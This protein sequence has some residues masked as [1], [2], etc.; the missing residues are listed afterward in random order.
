MCIHV[1]QVVEEEEEEEHTVWHDKYQ[2]NLTRFCYCVFVCVFVIFTFGIVTFQ[3]IIHLLFIS[4]S[5]M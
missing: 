1:W 2:R 4:L 5:I 3:P